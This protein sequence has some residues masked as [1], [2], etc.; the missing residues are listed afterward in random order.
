MLV[1]I[2]EIQFPNNFTP[3]N[4]SVPACSQVAVWP[5]LFG[6]GHSAWRVI[7]AE[8]QVQWKG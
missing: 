1:H 2:P 8:V 4:L 6:I 3:A 5:R 7:P